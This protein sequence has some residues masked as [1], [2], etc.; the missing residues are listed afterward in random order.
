MPSHQSIYIRREIFERLGY[1]RLDLGGSGDYEFV[2]RYFNFNDLKIKRL[3]SFIIKFS[4][5]GTST[6][7]YGSILRTQRVH[8]KC[9]K[10]NGKTPPFYMIPLK[11]L[12]KIPQFTKAII[13]RSKK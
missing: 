6:S 13:E 8:V 5:G 9:W 7:N 2:L 3:D 4:L 1:Y 10:L 11:L 12:R